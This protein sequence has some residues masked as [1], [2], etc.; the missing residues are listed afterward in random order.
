M[1]EPTSWQPIVFP[2][3]A[4]PQ[5]AEALRSQPTPDVRGHA[6]SQEVVKH[7]GLSARWSISERGLGALRCR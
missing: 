6:I 5:M 3:N 2:E 7:L 4:M 1:N